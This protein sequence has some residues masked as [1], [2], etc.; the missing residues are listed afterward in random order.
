MMRIISKIILHFSFAVILLLL[1]VSMLSAQ[2]YLQSETKR[3]HN[4]EVV[5]TQNEILI[6]LSSGQM[7]VHY[8]K[9]DE[10]YVNTNIYGEMTVYFPESNEVMKQY[11]A[12]FSSESEL[13]YHFFLQQTNDMGLTEGGFKAIETHMEDK[14][15]VTTWEAEEY[16]DSKFAKAK[17][18][19]ENYLPIF[20]SFSDENDK[21]L[22]KI[23]FTDW[24]TKDA[25][26]FPTRITQIDYIAEGDSILSRKLYKDVLTGATAN[27][28]YKKVE[29]PEDAKLIEMGQK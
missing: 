7:F 21:V 25:V 28:K 11:N 19:E 20:L 22:Q 3:L 9:P 13:I 6:E 24:E 29:I 12:F 27:E 8:S 18:V 16:N 5:T 14:Y 17:L 1:N 23:Y 26:V 15:L 10:F 2:V 4:D